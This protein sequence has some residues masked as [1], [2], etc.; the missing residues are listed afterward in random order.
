MIPHIKVR[1]SDAHYGSGGSLV[2]DIGENI[3]PGIVLWAKT[4][5][6][7]DYEFTILT[8]RLVMDINEYITQ[9][10]YQVVNG[11]WIANNGKEWVTTKPLFKFIM[12]D[13]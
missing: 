2:L 11:G 6:L 1:I 5:I 3:N 12:G 7:D 4:K 9:L 10:L 13:V 8:P